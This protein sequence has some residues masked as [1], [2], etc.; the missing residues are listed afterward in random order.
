[1]NRSRMRE[2]PLPGLFS[3]PITAYSEVI[4]PL[5]NFLITSG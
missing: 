3:E 5:V 2:E 1:M 4:P